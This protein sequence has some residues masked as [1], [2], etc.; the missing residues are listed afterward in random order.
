MNQVFVLFRRKVHNL[1]SLELLAS[2]DPYFGLL[3]RMA[4]SVCLG[5]GLN[6]QLSSTA[7]RRTPD[8]REA[9]LEAAIRKLWGTDFSQPWPRNGLGS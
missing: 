8:E 9:L 6:L 3:G 1:K 2:R 5:Q 4:V 7:G